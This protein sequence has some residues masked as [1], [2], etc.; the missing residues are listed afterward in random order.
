MIPLP[1]K[2]AKML[3]EELASIEAG[4]S[5]ERR[6]KKSG[7]DSAAQAAATA[8]AVHAA[9]RAA[10]DGAVFAQG[11]AGDDGDDDDDDDES[12]VDED[13]NEDDDD[14]FDDDD[15]DDD[16]GVGTITK[17]EA[18]LADAELTSSLFPLPHPCPP[19]AGSMGA[20]RRLRRAQQQ[21]RRLEQVAVRASGGVLILVRCTILNAALQSR[22]RRTLTR[23]EL[24]TRK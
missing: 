16:D 13:D 3:L 4:E 21:P 17:L 19:P 15:D 22:Q 10:Q 14:E 2:M 24:A 9:S 6:P 7:A 23:A 5:G 1:A 8:G 18:M 11:N 12:Y 20:R